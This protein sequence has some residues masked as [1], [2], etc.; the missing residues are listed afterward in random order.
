VH[1]LRFV[2]TLLGRGPLLAALVVATQGQTHPPAPSVDLTFAAPA[3]SLAATCDLKKPLVLLSVVVTSR[4]RGIYGADLRAGDQAGTL[5]GAITVPPL[6]PGG[7]SVVSIPL[8]RVG[9]TTAAALTGDHVISVTMWGRPTRI[10][11]TV[12]VPAS[13]CGAPAKPAKPVLSDTV[14][15]RNLPL[16]IA[17]PAYSQTATAVKRP[18]VQAALK[19]AP[20][21]NV[22]GVGSAQDCGAH[23]GPIGALVCPD[24]MKSGDLLLI[25]DW[26][27]GDGPDITGY[28]IYTGN[29]MNVQTGAYVGTLV[30]TRPSKGVTLFDVPKPSDGK[31]F[32]GKCFAVTAYAGANESAASPVFCAGGDAGAKTVTFA[33]VRELSVSKKSKDNHE[34]APD[35]NTTYGE[36]V[37]GYNYIAIKGG[38]LAD[39]AVVFI[40]RYAML[41]DVARLEG[42]R[43]VEAHVTLNVVPHQF[44]SPN[45]T[46]S[47]GYGFSDWWNEGWPDGTF[48]NPNMTLLN[49]RLTIDATNAVAQWMAGR[50]NKGIILRNDDE[51]LYAF[52]NKRCETHY[53]PPVLS[54][55]YY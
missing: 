3:Y 11:V 22:R 29:G 15:K 41:F 10:D 9:Y 55:T 51:N 27:P 31:G 30:A 1:M 34:I 20:P 46:T 48:G 38:V 49:G 54:V 35:N 4:D 44:S 52:T 12:P 50:F 23:V 24:M 42:R 32:A 16:A 25:W 33:P 2:L 14:A 19:I 39:T 43:V 37:V 53:G 17:T 40:S 47:V 8:E 45:C 28:K 36:R 7:S 13:L 26:Q 6:G 18:G 21:A 5:A